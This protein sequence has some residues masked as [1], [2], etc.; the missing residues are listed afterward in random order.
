[1]LLF[2]KMTKWINT[3]TW[4]WLHKSLPYLHMGNVIS[5]LFY[6]SSF[7]SS[8]GILINFYHIIFGLGFGD[9][10]MVWVG[11]KHHKFFYGDSW[12][13]PSN[14]FRSIFLTRAILMQC[15]HLGATFPSFFQFFA[16]YDDHDL[17]PWHLMN[18]NLSIFGFGSGGKEI[19]W[20]RGN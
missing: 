11:A 14:T 4:G 12:S 13:C 3:K 20:G 19:C 15:I 8:L 2:D 6:D 5:L 7:M 10:E 16:F 18:V 9:K 17:W 1:M